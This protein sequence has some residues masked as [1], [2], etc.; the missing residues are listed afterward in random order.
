MPSPD[1]NFPTTE[2][3][4]ISRIRSRDPHMAIC[5]LN[6]LCSQYHYPLYCYIRRRGLE[7]HDAQ[8]ALHDFLAKLLRNESLKKL[9]E[10]DGRLR[11]FLGKAL[12]HFLANWFRDHARHR[13]HI[14]LECEQE[15]A[16]NEGRFRRERLTEKDTPEH[17]FERKWA[18]ELLR[19]VERRLRAHYQKKNKLPLYDALRPGLAAGGSLRGEDTPR[20]AAT[21]GMSEGS[22]RTAMSRLLDEYREILHEEVAQTVANED[23]IE[24][25]I[26]YLIQVFQRQI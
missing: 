16:E 1:G 26:A 17:I 6:D 22:V 8:D 5:A 12:G 18:H 10:V 14:R 13:A 4:L 2:W 9:H 20:I 3:T 24:D 19:H 11:G 7:H 23:E 21:L 25:E 15:L